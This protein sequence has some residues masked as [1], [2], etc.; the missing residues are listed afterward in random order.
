MHRF[1]SEQALA[2]H[3]EYVRLLRVKYSILED[4]IKGIKN[5]DVSKVLTMNLN[6]RDKIEVQSLLGEIQCHDIYFDSF[7]A[8]N[9]LRSTLARRQYG[10]E[11]A[12]AM[13]ILHEGM[14]KD[15]KFVSVG[16]KQGRISIH[17]SFDYH[18][19]FEVHVPRLMI[20]TEEHAYFWDYGFYKEGYLKSALRYLNLARLD[21]N[22]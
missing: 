6:K 22:L 18:T 13:C 21:E 19:H 16:I 14:K 7:N 11:D 4:G 2:S 9:G 17:A 8:D 5:I 20:D 10:S 1:L 12:L 15:I 3:K